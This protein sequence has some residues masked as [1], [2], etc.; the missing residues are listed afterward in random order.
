MRLHFFA[1]LSFECL[2]WRLHFG[3]GKSG[4]KKQKLV[5]IAY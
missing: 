2:I 4:E 3:D 1:S 5:L